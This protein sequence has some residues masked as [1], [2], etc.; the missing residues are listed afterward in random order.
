MGDGSTAAS[1]VERPQ[2]AS[3]SKIQ[4]ILDKQSVF[5][6]SGATLPRAFR[7][8]QLRALKHAIETKEK[9]IFDA[10]NADLRRSET[11]AYLAEVGY[12]T[13]EIRHTIK[14]LGSW[15]RPR[16][17]LG[18]LAIAPSKSSVYQQPLGLNLIIAPWNYPIQL[19]FA[20]LIPCI[21]AGNVAVVKPSELAPASSAA[22]AE[23]LRDTFSEEYIAVV[24]GGVETSQSLL[25]KRWDHIFFTGG[26]QVG[27]IVA[28]AA[29]D[30]L[31]RCTLEL[32]GKSPTVV[33]SSADLDT[34]AKRIIWGKFFN[35]GQTCIAPDYV[36]AQDSIHDAL[37]S[38]MKQAIVDFFG[39]D[40]R[41][42][43]DLGRIINDRHFAR[44][45]KLIDRDKVAHGGE[46]D[47]SERFIAPTILQD[48][49]LDDAVM[50]E[51]IFGPILPVLKIRNVH[52]AET[53]IE[54]RPNPLALY[55]FTNEEEEERYVIERV[56][57]GGGCVNNVVVHFSDMGIPFG[58][59]GSSGLGAYHGKYGFDTFSHQKGVTKTGNFL[60]PSV[61]YPPYEG[62]LSVLRKL[63][64]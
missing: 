58:G 63:V 64:R 35:T 39:E 40:P 2:E 49:T 1:I 12:L 48:V 5:F 9:R 19:A 53:I 59:I 17:K 52:E 7:E 11:E 36:L 54:Q 16:T 26:T 55:L 41:K 23:I 10:L 46:T 51:E 37:V 8:E 6:R 25:A 30:H 57:F 18:P 38:R 62:K 42:S 4:E 21:A 50:N 13:G 47:A 24:E 15:M 45:E 43:P 27:K 60:D 28:H 33:M 22:I 44:L 20:P 31:A 3:D 56:S 32:G 34:A 29:A 61:K 14:H